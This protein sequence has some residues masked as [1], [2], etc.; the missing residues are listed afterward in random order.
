MDSAGRAKEDVS[1]PKGERYFIGS[2]IRSKAYSRNSRRF[3]GYA[4]RKIDNYYTFL[5]V[6]E[7][8][9]VRQLE[10]TFSEEV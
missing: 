2:R 6:R 3:A 1:L 7:I 9:V 5:S 4:D 10:Y 8:R